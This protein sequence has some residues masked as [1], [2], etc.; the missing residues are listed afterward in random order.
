[1]L[2]HEVLHVYCLGVYVEYI[3]FH[4]ISICCNSWSESEERER[5]ST[6]FNMPYLRENKLGQILPYMIEVYKKS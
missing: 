2:H 1:M 4:L 6:G 3:Y 5:F